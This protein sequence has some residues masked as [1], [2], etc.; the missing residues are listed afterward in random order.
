MAVA[1]ATAFFA[2]K[3]HLRWA[4]VWI[5]ISNVFYR[6]WMIGL[7]DYTVGYAVIDLALLALFLERARQPGGVIILPLVWIQ[8]AFMGVHL[9]GELFD[10]SGPFLGAERSHAWVEAWIRNRLFEAE[11]AWIMMAGGL[12]IAARRSRRA[13]RWGEKALRT[14][15]F[16]TARVAHLWRWLTAI[17]VSQSKA[18]K[19]NGGNAATWPIKSTR[20]IAPPKR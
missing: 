11:L 6:L 5:I 18:N 19:N 15:K 17:T 14:W 2:R 3:V 10:Y 4:M 7:N 12:N 20:R 13:H 8:I 16:S 9:S 1:L